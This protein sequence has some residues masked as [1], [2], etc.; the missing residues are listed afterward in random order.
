MLCDSVTLLRLVMYIFWNILL[1]ISLYFLSRF[2]V[3]QCSMRLGSAFFSSWIF[4]AQLVWIII[5]FMCVYMYTNVKILLIQIE[6]SISH[7]SYSKNKHVGKKALDHLT[8]LS[9]HLVNP[10]I[11]KAEII[12]LQPFFTITLHTCIWK[13]GKTR[14][15]I[16]RTVWKNVVLLIY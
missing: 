3:Y 8:T 1:L 2:R 16:T 11:R 14:R 6:H 4:S 5:H 12:K 9:H 13:G 15:Q 7:H 10:F